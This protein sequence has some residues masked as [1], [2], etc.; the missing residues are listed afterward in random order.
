M[1]RLDLKKAASDTAFANVALGNAAND[2]AVAAKGVELQLT[3]PEY[4][5]FKNDCGFFRGQY[6]PA[7]QAD[8]AAAKAVSAESAAVKAP[9]AAAPDPAPKP[10]A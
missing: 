4:Q 7:K 8:D 5:Q 1:K 9:A 2:A 10:S 6:L 3:D